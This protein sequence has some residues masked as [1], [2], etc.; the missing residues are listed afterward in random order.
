MQELASKD[1]MLH[2]IDCNAGFVNSTDVIL[3]LMPDGLHPNNVGMDMLAQVRQHHKS[4]LCLS[5][6]DC[7]NPCRFFPRIIC[8]SLSL[9]G[10]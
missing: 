1:P 7:K 6:M 2:Y 3:S 4:K 10:T 5:R 8:L 9:F